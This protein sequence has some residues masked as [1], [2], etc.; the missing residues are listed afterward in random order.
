LI[1]LVTKT[2]DS[3][4]EMLE[5]PTQLGSLIVIGWRAEVGQLLPLIPAPFEQMIRRAFGGER[6]LRSAAFG[7]CVR[8]YRTQSWIFSTKTREP[9]KGAPLPCGGALHQETC[10]NQS[11][12]KSIRPRTKRLLPPSQNHETIP[13]GARCP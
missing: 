4:P 10:R 13:Q 2:H 12:G 11:G 1:A 7:G 5:Q 3:L 8:T 6:R 9:S